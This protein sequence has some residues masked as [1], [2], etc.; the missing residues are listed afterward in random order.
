LEMKGKEMM[1]D[2]DFDKKMHSLMAMWTENNEAKNKGEGKG[3][4]NDFKIGPSESENEEE[5]G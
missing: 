1:V 5:D 2:K 4:Y 3:N